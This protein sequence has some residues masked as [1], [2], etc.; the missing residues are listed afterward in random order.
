M[1]YGSFKIKEKILEVQ[2][3]LSLMGKKLANFGSNKSKIKKE[4]K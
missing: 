3:L 4:R 1:R 2:C